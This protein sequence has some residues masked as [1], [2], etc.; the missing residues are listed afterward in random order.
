M[1]ELGNLDVSRD[2][3]DVRMVV[4]AYRRL[5]ETPAAIGGT[6]NVCSGEAFSLAEVIA[7]LAKLSNHELEVRV[8]P[9]FVRANEIKK[10]YAVI[11]IILSQSLALLRRFLWLILC[12]GCLRRASGSNFISRST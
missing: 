9:A 8:N 5:L 4:S 12:A 7:I 6:F 2:F 3:S 10:F 11:V 1:I